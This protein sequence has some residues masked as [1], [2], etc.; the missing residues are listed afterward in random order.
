VSTIPAYTKRAHTP[1]DFAFAKLVN[2]KLDVIKRSH[3]L[4]KNFNSGLTVLNTAFSFLICNP[5]KRILT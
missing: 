1:N 5:A 3:E 4:L 2:V